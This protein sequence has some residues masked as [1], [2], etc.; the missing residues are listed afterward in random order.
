MGI[1][2][3]WVCKTH[4][5]AHYS[6]RG[7]EGVDFQ[8]LIRECDINDCPSRCFT[9]GRITVYG[10]GDID[11]EEYAQIW[12]DYEKRPAAVRKRRLAAAD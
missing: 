11:H 10:D 8:A 3:V 4:R 12:P 5:R 9:M 7:E 2:L 1:N 6:M